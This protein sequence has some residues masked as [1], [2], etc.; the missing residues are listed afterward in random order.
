MKSYEI[1]YL[2]VP[3]LTAEEAAEYHEGIKKIIAKIK[4]IPGSEQTPTRK[5]LAYPIKKK[6]EAYLTSLD[7][8]AESTSVQELKK[9]IAKEKNILRHLIISKKVSKDDDEAPKKRRSLKPEKAKLKE[10]DD[11]IDEIV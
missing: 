9:L 11:K 7:F 5:T 4:G 3:D 10:L 6:T 1:T 2:I 8:E